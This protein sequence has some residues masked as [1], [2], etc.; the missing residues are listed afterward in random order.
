METLHPTPQ[1]PI[2]EKLPTLIPGFDLIANGGVPKGR[3]TLVSGTAGS[4]KTIFATQ[5]LV[6]GIR[7]REE[8]GVFVTFEESPADIRY[9]VASLGW[10]I[11]EWEAQSLWAF[12]D[13]APVAE[14]T[15]VIGG[16][17]LG[18]LLA[19]IEY[20][21]S[22]VNARRV[23]LDSLGAIFS[24]FS[25]PLVI[26]NEMLRVSARLKQL[27]VTTLVT[28]ERLEEYGAIARYG[29]EEFVADNVIILRNSLLEE[30]RR[31]TVEILKF[32]GTTHQKGEFPFTV[33]PESG[34]VVLP[35]SAIELGQRSSNVR[36]TSGIEALD[37]M[38]GGG[39][40]RDS[41]L[42]V[43]GA[44]GTGKTLLTTSFLEGRRETGATQF[45]LRLRG[46]P[47][48]TYPQCDGVGH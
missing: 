16:Y 10:N 38:C 9:N 13:C 32:R 18:A 15:L 30:K 5:F 8:P 44:T 4:A 46:E 40:F 37:Q 23:V 20:A 7:Q 27:G 45:A 28:S 6:E 2:V 29:V 43:S 31:R 42:L 19:R 22:K 25:D 41:I 36:T 26:R 1:T 24:Q 33:Q 12:V 48:T 34:V 35:L 39:F 21:I 11:A 17:D 3:T 14:E 47:R